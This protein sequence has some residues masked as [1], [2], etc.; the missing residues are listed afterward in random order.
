MIIEIV[1]I[2][3]GDRRRIVSL[4]VV[5]HQRKTIVIADDYNRIGEL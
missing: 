1:V 3:G 4:D 5:V 2:T